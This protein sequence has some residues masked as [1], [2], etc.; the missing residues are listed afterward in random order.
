MQLNGLVANMC[1]YQ[2]ND[3]IRRSLVEFNK[4]SSN[5]EEAKFLANAGLNLFSSEKAGGAKSDLDAM[6][7]CLNKMSAI[8]GECTLRHQG[9]IATNPEI[10][11]RLEM[12]FS[13]SE[14]S[15]MQSIL[16]EVQVQF[17]SVVPS[18]RFLHQAF[19]LLGHGNSVSPDFTVETFAIL[20]ER[21]KRVL[22]SVP[23]FQSLSEKDQVSQ[24]VLP[25]HGQATS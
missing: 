13:N 15:W 23:E 6:L 19:N 8:F 3:V 2:V 12:R 10:P 21:A 4:I 24:L 22:F 17:R 20:I 14:E 5:F 1:L 25:R 16:N 11:M 7:D 18:D 9:D